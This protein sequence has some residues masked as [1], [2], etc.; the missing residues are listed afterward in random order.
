L[1]ASTTKSTGITITVRIIAQVRRL[2]MRG[3]H[4]PRVEFH[5]YP[6]IASARFAPMPWRRYLDGLAGFRTKPR[7]AWASFC[8]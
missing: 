7:H 6:G 3:Q 4:S 1:N 2:P 8:Q 5:T